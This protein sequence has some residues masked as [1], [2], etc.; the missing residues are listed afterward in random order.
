MNQQFLLQINSR[1]R[2]GTTITFCKLR[3][4]KSTNIPSWCNQ[5]CIA[6][7]LVLFSVNKLSMPLPSKGSW[8]QH[9]NNYLTSIQVLSIQPLPFPAQRKRQIS[10]SHERAHK[11]NGTICQ[12]LEGSDS[13][14]LWFTISNIAV[15]ST[16]YEPAMHTDTEYFTTLPTTDFTHNPLITDM[17]TQRE[18]ARQYIAH[19]EVPRWRSERRNEMQPYWAQTTIIIKQL[20]KGTGEMVC[21]HTGLSKPKI[22]KVKQTQRRKKQKGKGE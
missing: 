22:Q 4:Q 12:W 19:K 14:E 20:K 9:L 5:F 11:C 7:I 6:Q 2:W 16:S 15:L 1:R 3:W 18:I 17:A 8:K 21:T 10:N 13:W